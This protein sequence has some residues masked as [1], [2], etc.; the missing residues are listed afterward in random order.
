MKRFPIFAAVWVLNALVL[1]A[2]IFHNVSIT[3]DDVPLPTNSTHIGGLPP[4][5]EPIDLKPVSVDLVQEEVVDL[6]PVHPKQKAVRVPPRTLTR[7]SVVV[8][9]SSPIITKPQTV[10]YKHNN[11]RICDKL[12]FS[13][14]R[15]SKPSYRS[16]TYYATPFKV[17]DPS[18][19]P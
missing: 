12:H 7:S 10:C 1:I 15:T 14:A 6:P 5:P 11:V 17:G 2:I 19:R 18:V 9:K 16:N 8:P 4:V 3:P 13:R